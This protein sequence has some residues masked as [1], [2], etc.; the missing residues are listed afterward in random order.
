MTIA[1]RVRVSLPSQANLRKVSLRTKLVASVLVLVFAALTLISSAST[2]ALHT[3]LISRLDNQLK[4]LSVDAIGLTREA[5]V[6]QVYMPM[7][8]MIAFSSVS[9]VTKPYANSRMDLESL[10]VLITGAQRT[11]ELNEQTY[12]TRSYDRKFMWRVR[13]D[14]LD[15]GTVMSVGERMTGV[16]AVIA[17]LIWVD[18]LVG[19]GVLLA[20]A[21]V[22]AALVRQSLVPLLQIERTAGRIAAG[23]YSQRVPDPEVDGGEPTTEL[24]RL[25]TALNSMLAQIEMAFHARAASEQQAKAAAESAQL[26]EGRAV[27]SEEK[28]RQF[29]ADA[30]HELR[31]PLTTI[32][33]FAE[34]YRQGAVSD[35]DAVA[36]LVR[37]IEDEAARMGLLVEDLLLLARL[38]RERPLNLA[39]VELPVLAMDAVQAARATAPDRTIELDIHDDQERLVAYGDDARLR[40]VIGNLMTNALVHTPPEA[41]VTLRLHA[42]GENEAV[43]EVSDTGPGLSDEQRSRVFERFYRADGARTR[44]TDREATGTGLGLAIVAAIVRSHNGSVDVFS[45]PGQGATFRVTLPT[46]NVDKGFTENIQD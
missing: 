34:L 7:D 27:A 6:V 9:G 1:E 41:T 22:G 15:N 42:G 26:S 17:R 20:L 30:S 32:R 13:I 33:G 39:P 24:G 14:V 11:A 3:Y 18:V 40:Q 2:I 16:D 12:T 29:V 4:E 36:R 8:Y 25:S 37:R 44:N 28:M 5:S 43:V 45:E 46:V 38:D 21:I 23:D 35:P 31:T 10:P 19:V